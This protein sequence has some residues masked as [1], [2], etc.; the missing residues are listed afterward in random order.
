[1]AKAFRAQGWTVWRDDHIAP[2][3]RF[4]KVIADELDKAR[5]V[6]W[7]RISVN[8]EWVREEA[9]AGKQRDV[10]LPALI[11]D[12]PLPFG[13]RMVQTANIVGWAPGT[14][15][16]E[17]DTLVASIEQLAP[18]PRPPS[19][20]PPREADWQRLLAMTCDGPRVRPSRTAQAQ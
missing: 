5:C 3:K 7:S 11:E 19:A 4:D 8:K 10:L 14:P 6:L 1:V 18:R 13:F 2:G 12:V 16:R 20:P 17:F 9:M 15:H